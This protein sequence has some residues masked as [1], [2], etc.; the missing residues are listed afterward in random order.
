MA[1]AQ[2]SKAGGWHELRQGPGLVRLALISTCVSLHAMDVFVTSTILP[3]VVADIDGV[4]YYAWPSALYLI[5]SIVGAASGGMVG[6]NLGL[7][8]ALA[9]AVSVYL[10]GALFCAAAP[11]MAVFLMGRTTQGLGAGMLVALAYTMVRQLFDDDLRPRVFAVMSAIW[12]LAALVAPLIAG[13]FAQMGFWRGVYWLT[14]PIVVIMLV[15]ARRAVPGTAPS[16]DGS[17]LPWGRLLL[18]GAAVLCVTVSGRIDEPLLRL[19]LIAGALFGVGGMLRLDHLADNPLLP[20]APTSF[21]HPVGTGYWI[22]FLMSLSFAPLSIFLPLLAQRL[23]SVEPI[24]AGYIAAVMSLGWSVGSFAAAGAAPSLQRI[25]IVTGP[26]CLLIGI[27]GQ[28]LFVASGPLAPLIGLIFLSGLGIGQ[29]HLHVSNNVMMA[30]RKGEETLTAGAIPTMQSLGIAF[31]AATAGLLANMA[32][33]SDG[34]SVA[35]L[36]D[37]TEWIWGFALIP[38]GCTVLV[39][40]RLVWLIN[41]APTTS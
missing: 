30:A 6:A 39:A 21:R 7:R 13:A 40:A 26:L 8:R 9:I 11:H 24:M 19:I 4:A 34:I 37:V 36:T 22:F 15:L 20:S 33:L 31:G 17:G 29:C 10:L 3:S 27:A 14:V 5:T 1:E 23:H 35:I 18:L 38:A 16:G 12:G 25:L 28:G 2:N 41:R 32:G